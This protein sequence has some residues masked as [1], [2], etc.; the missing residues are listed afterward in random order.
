MKTLFSKL[1]LIAMLVSIM[2]ICT[3]GTNPDGGIQEPR[4]GVDC[5]GIWTYV[6]LSESNRQSDGTY[7]VT[8]P[9][10]PEGLSNMY[11]PR[12]PGGPRFANFTGNTVDIVFRSDVLEEI[13]EYSISGAEP[14]IDVPVNLWIDPLHGTY[15]TYGSGMVCYYYVVLHTN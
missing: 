5:L 7:L 6:Q 4:A 9:I 11:N 13:R 12:G 3:Y 8:I 14:V 10:P 15:N 2:V 1:A